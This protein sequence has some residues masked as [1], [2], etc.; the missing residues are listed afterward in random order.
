MA[1]DIGLELP[2]RPRNVFAKALDF[3]QENLNTNSSSSN[4]MGHSTEPE[5]LIL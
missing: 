5:N 3:G 1:F 2:S 4:F